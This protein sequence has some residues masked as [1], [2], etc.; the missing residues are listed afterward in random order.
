MRLQP[1][2]DLRHGGRHRQQRER[3]SEPERQLAGLLARGV[4]GDRT[5]KGVLLAR[6]RATPPGWS[7]AM[8]RDGRSWS[9]PAANPV[10]ASRNGTT[11]IADWRARA[12]L[13]VKPSPYRKRT[14]ESTARRRTPCRPRQAPRVLG[15]E[16]V[17]VHLDGHGHRSGSGHGGVFHAEAS[18][19]QGPALATSLPVRASA[20]D[21]STCRSAR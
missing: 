7:L 1:P 13:L 18:L 8:T 15:V 19:K 20:S 4:T 21:V 10:N 3:Q 12:R 9:M 11:A 17:A 14:N 6:S 16:L 2:L 5:G